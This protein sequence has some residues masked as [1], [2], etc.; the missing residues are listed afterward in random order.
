VGSHSV[1]ASAGQGR[2][3]IEAAVREAAAD[4][5]ALSQA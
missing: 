3:L 1:L 4:L 5:R 2:Q